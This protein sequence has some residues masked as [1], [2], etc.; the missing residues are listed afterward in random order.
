MTFARVITP[1]STF[2]PPKSQQ[3][4]DQI[5]NGILNFI[6][7]GMN[8][9]LQYFQ[10]NKRTFVFS[11]W[12]HIRF[13]ISGIQESVSYLRFRLQMI[14]EIAVFLFG[15]DFDQIMR[16]NSININYIDLFAKYVDTFLEIS[17]DDYL[18]QLGIISHDSLF[19]E[20]SHY[21]SENIPTSQ[22]PHDLPFIDC[23]IFR[24]Y[25]I[26]S[27]FN[28]SNPNP[29]DYLNVFILSIFMRIEYPKINTSTIKSNIRKT[30]PK[31]DTQT[32]KDYII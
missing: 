5:I 9:K 16:N 7:S 21:L 10:T 3:Q 18:F 2:Y 15:P 29:I 23:I 4:D 17:E 28:L 32:Q 27:R 6:K 19:S 12:N 11:T 14:R 24:N 26:V 20:Y 1:T 25:Q 30:I 13:I 22:F 8:C 31:K